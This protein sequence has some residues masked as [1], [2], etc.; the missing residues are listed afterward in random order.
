MAYDRLELVAAIN[1]VLEQYQREHCETPLGN[2]L[3]AL[4]ALGFTA[5]QIFSCAPNL[6]SRESGRNH[7]MAAMEEGI[8]GSPHTLN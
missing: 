8:G 1:E 5:G 3:F 4:D 7:F 6:A 2:A